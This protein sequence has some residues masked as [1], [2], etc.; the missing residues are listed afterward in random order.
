[1]SVRVVVADD[2]DLLRAGLVTVLASDAGIEVVAEA[3]D[4]PTAVELAVRHR[5]DV[6]LMDVEMPGGDGITATR[7]IRRAVPE[8]R[9]LVLTMFDLDEYVV[10]GLHAG[11]SGFLLKTTE[12]TGLVHAVLACAAGQATVG[13]TVLARLLEGVATKDRAAQAHPGLATLT[14]RERDVLVAMTQGLSNAEI[15]ASLFLAES[16]VKSHVAQVLT[17]LGVRDR[18]Q[19]VVVAHR[20]GLA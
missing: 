19:A 10:E 1:M 14:A 2:H 16:T 20:S 6:V 17:K 9:V 13:P 18:L 8:S 15:G 5:P 7:E 3:S 11:A 4:G 12:P